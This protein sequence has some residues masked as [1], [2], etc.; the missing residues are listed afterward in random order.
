[1]FEENQRVLIKST[2]DLSTIHN[3]TIGWVDKQHTTPEFWVVII[4]TGQSVVFHESQLEPHPQSF[5]VPERTNV[6][7]TL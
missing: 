1:M 7:F 5:Y 4:Y 3:G 2:K 6:G